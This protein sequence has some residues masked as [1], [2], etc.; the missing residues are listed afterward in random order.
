MLFCVHA[1]DTDTD[2]DNKIV[3]SPLKMCKQLY[4]LLEYIVS[5]FLFADNMD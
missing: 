2:I 3:S 4:M 5:S 1:Y